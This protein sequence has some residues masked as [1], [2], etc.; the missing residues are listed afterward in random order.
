M[1]RRS[2]KKA[3][4]LLFFSP[5]NFESSPEKFEK[6]SQALEKGVQ[7]TPFGLEVH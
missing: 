4:Q 3:A 7:K 5:E 2:V 1:L 6:C